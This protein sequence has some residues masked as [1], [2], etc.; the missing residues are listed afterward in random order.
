MPVGNATKD[1]QKFHISRGQLPITGQDF[2]THPQWVG[3]PQITPNEN[4]N[5]EWLLTKL[6]YGDFNAWYLLENKKLSQIFH[7]FWKQIAQETLNLKNFFNF[8]LI[9][10]SYI[11]TDLPENQAHFSGFFRG[12]APTLLYLEKTLFVCVAV[13]EVSRRISTFDITWRPFVFPLTMK[14]HC[15]VSKGRVLLSRELKTTCTVQNS[16][17]FL[18]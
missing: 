14:I 11:S 4:M 17:L 13:Y 8:Q 18:A 16:Y 12:I 1:F 3:F 6:E 15:H 5:D 9:L 10:I 7:F 2:F